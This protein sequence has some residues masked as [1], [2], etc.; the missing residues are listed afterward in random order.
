VQNGDVDHPHI[1]STPHFWAVAERW[2][3]VKSLYPQAVPKPP[4]KLPET[5]RQNWESAEA[6]V[7][8]VRGRMQCSGPVTAEQ[9]GEKL[10]LDADQVFTALEAVE[11]EG[12]VMRGQFTQESVVN[13]QRPV[14]GTD[15]KQATDGSSAPNG[16]SRRHPSAL[17]P[18]SSTPTEWCERRLLAR[19]HRKTLDGLRRQI[20]PAEPHDFIRFL[21]RWH[22]LE[23]GTQWHGRT[24][25]RKAITQ[26]QGLELAAALWERRILP[27]RCDEYDLRW[28]DELS[29]SG[30]LAWG[31]LCPPHKDS[32]DAPSGA[33]L[34]RAAPISLML[35][36]NLPWLLP[37]QRENVEAH[38]RAG[39]AAVLE[40]LRQRGALFPD[41]LAALTGLLPSQL[42]EA[43]HELAALGLATADAF[44]AV[45][46]ISGTA[47]D[48]RR[49]EKRRRA[50]RLR[51][52]F[53][54]SPTGRWS[55]FPGF[56]PKVDEGQA[57]T[58]WAWQLLRRWGIVFR[59]LLDRESAAPFWSRLV[60]VYRRLEARGE[61]RGG[62]FVRGVAGEQYAL[63]EAVELLR[64]M[65]DEPSE[66]A[67][68]VL[69]AAD[70]VN[71]CGL[72][73]DEPRIPAVHT[74]TVAIR[75]GHLVA[76]CQAGEIQ[77]FEN[78]SPEAIEELVHRLRLQYHLA[79]AG[80]QTAAAS[81]HGFAALPEAASVSER[82]SR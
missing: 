30:E 26:L 81:A 20:Q 57:A 18:R 1:S 15:P 55:Q 13:G 56:L 46:T 77:W 53:T 35:R 72:I 44:T 25:L 6:I 9:L 17:A 21:V 50:R 19:I 24:G 27:A 74:N 39:A 16:Q 38:C 69:S 54:T 67:T 78:I 11:A 7:T 33:G 80:N 28:L 79:E 70:P 82:R 42:D 8:L 4:V 40:A 65:R 2:P 64:S 32:D 31:R 58:S 47:T 62:R 12:T 29:M 36:E 5:V 75:D 37:Q 41:E 3:L 14:V 48:R 66:N 71:L 51:R 52:E 59:D 76:A 10:S 45:R 61:I 73:T 60:P 22:H 23:S 34:S 68:L 43:L 49:A 63:P